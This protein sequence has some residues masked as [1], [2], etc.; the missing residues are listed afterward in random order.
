MKVKIKK[1]G[2]VKEF[3][4][5]SSWKDVTLEKWI[6]LVDFHNGTKSSEALETIAEL[7]NIPK[8]LIKQLELKDVALIMS[9]V[10]EMQQDQN[11]SLKRVIEIEGKRYGFHPDLSSITLGEWSDIETFIK[12]D[13]EKNLPEVMAILYREIEEEKNDIYTIKA[14]D[15]NISIRTEVMKKM[16]AEQVQSALVFFYHFVTKLSEIL[17]SYLMERLKEMNKQLPQNLLPKSGDTLG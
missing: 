16:S 12:Q 4:L 9:K 8:D 7:S 14:Y 5:I 15:G 2:K 3:K 11:S 13:I 10:A 1:K 17:P 6:K